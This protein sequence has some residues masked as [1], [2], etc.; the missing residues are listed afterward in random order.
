[1]R[2]ILDVMGG[3][4]PPEIIIQCAIMAA[5]EYD[6]DILL[7]GDKRII[8]E[9]L[10]RE[11]APFEKFSIVN[12][13]Q[14]IV[15]EDNPMCVVQDKKSSSMAPGLRLLSEGK[16]DAFVSCGNTGALLTGAT[17]IVRRIKGIRRAAL[18]TILPFANPLLL[19]DC[20]ANVTVTS[21]YLEQF[22]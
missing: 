20:G 8:V 7:V 13:P 2:V 10:R 14:Y 12:A 6:A 5:R 1:M 11:N 19:L 22:A 3:D 18:G 21:D 9:T 17:L 4:N 16:G 15:M